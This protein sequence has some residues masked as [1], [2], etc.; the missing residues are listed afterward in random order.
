[1]KKGSSGSLFHARSPDLGAGL[2][3]DNGQIWSQLREPAMI[4][5]AQRILPYLP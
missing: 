4:T 1:M 5:V 3:G 2:L